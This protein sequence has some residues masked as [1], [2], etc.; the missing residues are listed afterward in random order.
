[1]TWPL[2]LRALLALLPLLLAAAWAASATGEQGDPPPAA[3]P[4]GFEPYRGGA[5]TTG[6]PRQVDGAVTAARVFDPDE[7]VRVADT[8]VAPHRSIA[9]LAALDSERR[10]AWICS[11]VVVS[12]TAV[13]TAAHCVFDEESGRYVP[14]VLVIP[15]RDATSEPFGLTVATRY[16]VPN[17]WQQ[18]G[19]YQFDFAV[20]ALDGAPFG[21]ALAPYLVPASAPDSHFAAASRTFISAGYPADKPR[22]TQWM[23]SGFPI[24]PGPELLATTMDSAGGQSGSPV[25]SVEGNTGYIIGLLSHETPV[26]NFLL[27]ITPNHLAAMV[28]YCEELGCTLPVRDLAADPPAPAPTPPPRPLLPYELHIPKVARD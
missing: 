7:R 11:G 2:R 28:R 20:I 1:M 17:G 16:L 4:P 9:W 8:T 27:R 22:G 13:L 24:R 15:G 25:W 12:P 18:T 14:E 23:A 19:D 21:N 3:L 26:A 10:P 6:W 5:A